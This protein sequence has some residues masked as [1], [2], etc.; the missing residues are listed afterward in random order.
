MIRGR[1]RATVVVGI[2]A[3]A[4]AGSAGCDV[5][6]GE[7]G[8]NVG[9]ASGKATDQW[10]RTYTIAGN[11][12]FAVKNVNGTITIEPSADAST[13]EVRAERTTRATSDEAARELLKKLEI[14][15][16]VKPDAIRIETK[17]PKTF[18]RSGHEIKYFVKVPAGV[19]VEAKTVNGGVR[20]N[21]V[22][23]DV[24]AESVNGG[25]KGDGLSGHL[26][27]STTNGGIEISL[28]KLADAGVK[29]ETVN[30]GVDLTLPKAA[31]ANISARV[32]NGGLHTGDLPIET[33]GEQSRRRLD[34]RMNGG[35]S[36]VELA[37]TNGGI[38]L[39]GK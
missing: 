17:A 9:L 6:V 22:P 19:V 15:E 18:G 16:D 37:T 13:I 25:V 33:V 30:G 5:N 35:G 32:T 8:F 1:L 10:T 7:G 11:G 38:H 27:A 23:N 2:L 28:D 20:V 4:A 26:D 12:R 21:K 24:T 36:P 39:S 34:G 31:K 3:V 29:L 14:V